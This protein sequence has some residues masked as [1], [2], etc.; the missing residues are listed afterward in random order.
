MH[1]QITANFQCD[2]ILMKIFKIEFSH[3]KGN[4]HVELHPHKHDIMIC[5][6]TPGILVELIML[7]STVE[8]ISSLS[9]I[10]TME[11]CSVWCDLLMGQN[12][13]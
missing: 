2:E 7:L 1:T 3:G 9:V 10:D 13:G 12:I 11:Y 6:H 5:T 4:F 8:M